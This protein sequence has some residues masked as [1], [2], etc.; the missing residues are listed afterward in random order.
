MIW[1]EYVYYL[2]G[3]PSQCYWQLYWDKKNPSIGAVNIDLWESK[4]YPSKYQIIW[5]YEYE[6]LT[7]TSTFF[8]CKTDP[9]AMSLPNLGCCDT[10]RW[11]RALAVVVR[12]CMVHKH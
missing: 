5:H 11:K 3:V 6:L 4:N 2:K 12:S 1:H 10:L 8:K 7:K 9:T